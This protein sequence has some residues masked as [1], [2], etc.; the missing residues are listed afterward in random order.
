MSKTIPDNSSKTS[1]VPSP[2]LT[3]VQHAEAAADTPKLVQSLGLFSSTAIVAGSMIGS[4]VFL[5]DADIARTANSPALVAGAWVVT[6]ILTMIGALAYGELAAMMPKAGGQYVYLRE[7]LGP[8][9]GFLYGWTLFLVIQTGTIA[10]VCVAFGKFLGVFFPTISTTHW[11][12]HIAHVPGIPVG[13]MVLGNMDIGV[14]TANLTGIVIVFLLAFVNMFGV[15]LGSM[16]QNIFTSAKALSLAAL[17]LLTFTIGRNATAWSA[18]FGEN[19]SEFW[20][21]AGWSSLH[22]VQVG[23]GGPVLFVNL[24]VILAVVQVG[25]LFSADAWNN[26]TFTAGEVKNPKRNIPLSLIFGTGFV[27]TVYFLVTLGYLLVLPMHG[28]PHGTTAMARGLQY[29]SEDR[30]ATAALEVIF[31]S[32]GASLMAAA[33]LVSTFGCANGLSLAGSRVY[34]AMSRDGLFFK[35]VGK[36]SKRYRTP[37]A[38]LFVQACWTAVLCISGSYSQ[39]LDYIIVAVLV[40]YILTIVGLFVLRF[41]RPDAPRPYKALGYPVLPAIYIIMASWICIVLL[42]YK[43]QYTWPGLVLVLLGIPVYLFWSRRSDSQMKEI[44]TEPDPNF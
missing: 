4:G 42:R 26:I 31:H 25:S 28:D 24:L 16:I 17:V 36:L 11:L 7:S 33:I 43:P 41:K 22:P 30:V 6:G 32:G 34:Y 10:A 15:K 5:V 21:N 18:N 14:N 2:K 8:L 40:F 12:W 38:G 13:P 19:L 23:V 37:A 9:W 44:Q 3:S 39:L 27:L 1:P 20:K 29:A 35:S